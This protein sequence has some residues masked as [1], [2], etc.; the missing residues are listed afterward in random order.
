[1]AM[2]NQEIRK[3]TM[4][5]HKLRRMPKRSKEEGWKDNVLHTS[6][7]ALEH[8][9]N[10]RINKASQGNMAHITKFL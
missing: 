5:S 10:S 1:M 8:T 9:P 6:S 2:W 4:H 7:H 3:H